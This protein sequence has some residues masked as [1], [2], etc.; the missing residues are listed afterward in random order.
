MK[1]AILVQDITFLGG[2]EVVTLWLAKK[3]S[4]MHE[5]VLFSCKKQS[6]RKLEDVENLKISYLGIPSEQ[7][8]LTENDCANIQS[9]IKHGRFDIV[10]MPMG[11][12]FRRWYITCDIE[13]IKQLSKIS[14]IYFVLHES[15]RFHLKRYNT[16]ND[17]LLMLALKTANH[18]FR[19]AREVKFFFKNI[20]RYVNTFVTLSTGCQR[21]MKECYGLDSIVMYNPYNFDS[22]PIN[23]SEKENTILCVG[24]LSGEKNVLLLLKVWNFIKNKKNWNLKIIGDGPE[25]NKLENFVKEN[26]IAQV[27]FLGALSHAAVISFFRAS[28]IYCHFSFYEGFPTVISECMNYKNVP[29]V[30]RYDGFSDELLKTDNSFIC[31]YNPKKIANTLECLMSNSELLE[32]YAEKAYETCC[33][34]YKELNSRNYDLEQYR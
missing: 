14:K 10:I 23:F 1:I 26:H 13:L 8:Y 34:F 18:Y 30:T 25:R 11:C 7:V 16:T 19:Y 2:L 21:E 22:A 17:N 4:G 28:K 3:L 15:P 29:V 12:A 20:K 5:T 24:R 6:E 9:I 33:C 32:K 31:D 27:E